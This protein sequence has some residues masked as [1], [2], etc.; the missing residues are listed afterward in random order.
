LKPTLLN[1]EAVNGSQFNDFLTGNAAANTLI[2]S[3][4]DDILNGRTGNDTLK[5]GDGADQFVF[6]T[7]LNA[8]SNFDRIQDFVA[9][10]DRFM[11]D[12]TVFAGLTNGVLA[13]DAFA[14]GAGR[15]TAADTSDRIIYNL[16]SGVLYYDADG[17]A[18]GSAPMAFAQITSTIKP[19]LT[20]SDFL[21]FGG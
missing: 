11:L 14:S 4:G 5:G 21:V 7:A 1:F 19:A 13:V 18:T 3:G 16:T 10:I 15:K 2:G 9:A 12:R 8:A 6:D 20:A 17:S